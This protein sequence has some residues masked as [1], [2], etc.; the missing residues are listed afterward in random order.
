[1]RNEV[2]ALFRQV[3]VS[4][5]QEQD[6]AASQLM[7]AQVRLERARQRVADLEVLSAHFKAA[8]ADQ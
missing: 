7:E 6:A 1:M 2:R 5:Y 8:E 3:Q 4:A